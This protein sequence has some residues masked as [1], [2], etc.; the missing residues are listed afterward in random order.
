[1]RRRDRLFLG[2]G[3]GGL[4]I[5][6]GVHVVIAVPVAAYQRLTVLGQN[7]TPDDVARAAWTIAAG[8]LGGFAVVAL[9]AV[10]LVLCAHAL[11]TDRSRHPGDDPGPD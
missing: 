5:L 11:A 8:L 10:A 2:V 3:A 6:G 1:M 7:E 9:G 4:A